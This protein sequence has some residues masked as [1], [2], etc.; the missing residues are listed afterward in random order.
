MATRSVSTVLVSDGQ[1]LRLVTELLQSARLESPDGGI[2]EAADLQWWWRQERP[3][4][5]HGQL[6]WLDASG[7]PQA[8]VVI[9]EFSAST[10]CDVLVR[11]GGA[12]APEL[13]WREAVRRVGVLG[14]AAEFAVRSDDAAGLA[15]LA[16][17][18]YRASGQDWVLATWMAAGRRPE[19]PALPPGY[20]LVSR[21]TDDRQ[22]HPMAVRNGD[23]V[24]SRLREC[25][26]YRPELDLAVIA[27]GGEVAGYGLFWAD[28]V[29]KV[30]LVE[31]MRT[32]DAHQ[33]RGIASHVLA[34]GLDLLAA[35]GCER[36]KVGNDIGIYLRAGFE[37]VP[38]VRLASYVPARESG[39]AGSG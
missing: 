1:Y 15:A 19:V 34:A 8:A 16:E 20:F 33:G 18:G 31:P 32:E 24:Q 30:G 13:A 35:A 5:R 25:S 3:S 12:V 6:F 2:W 23:A 10:Q 39:R 4:D 38:D 21:S 22:P 29:T 7:R 27:P 17:A 11:P 37:P 14:I 28:P 9:T 26:L 36:L